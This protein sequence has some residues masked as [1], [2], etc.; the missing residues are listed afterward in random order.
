MQPFACFYPTLGAFPPP[1]PHCQQPWGTIPTD[2]ND[3][4][5]FL[6]LTPMMGH[7]SS[8]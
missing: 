6:L 8:H 3:G 4:A 7:Y 1:P 2:T 5:C